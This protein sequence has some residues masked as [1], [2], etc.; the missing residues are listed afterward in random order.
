LEKK[1][2]PGALLPIL[3]ALQEEFGDIDRAAE[4]IIAHELNIS[5]AEVHG[6]VTSTHGSFFKS[7]DAEAAP[8]KIA[9]HIREFWDP[10]MRQ[11]IFAYL[12]AGGTGLGPN[13]RKAIELLRTGL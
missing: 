9:D 1:A 6:V 3:H 13:S 8:A 7:Q 12:E 11:Q 10:R 5:R 2:M 4:L